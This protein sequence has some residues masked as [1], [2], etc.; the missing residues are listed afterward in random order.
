M[1]ILVYIII[2]LIIFTYIYSYANRV[3]EAKKFLN[4]E[5]IGL[6]SVAA[7]FPAGQTPLEERLGE[8]RKAISDGATEIDIVI[9]RNLAISGKWKDMYNEIKAMKDI[10]GD[11]HLKCI[12]ATG[13]LPTQNDVYIASMVCMMAGADFIKTSTGKEKIN[14]TLIVGLVMARAVRKYYNIRNIKVGIKPAGGISTANSGI[15]W[16][17][18][19]EQELGIEWTTKQLFRIGA[20]SLLNN[21]EQEI[22]RC[23]YGYPKLIYNYTI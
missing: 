3:K 17:L 21:I 23:I 7:G 15:S 9:S 5:D 8:I 11:A 1:Y 4:D 13:E 22:D 20:S 10:C 14:A 2:I 19:M 18:M 16:L 12:L 6:A